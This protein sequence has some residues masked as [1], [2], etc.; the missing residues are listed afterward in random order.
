MNFQID[1]VKEVTDLLGMQPCER[2]DKVSRDKNSHTLLLSGVY[3]SGDDA[4][5]RAKF[6]MAQGQITMLL[7]ARSKNEA[8]LALIHKA[9]G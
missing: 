4:L 1:A 2:S 3:V 7:T 6:A 5:A 8:P 9:V